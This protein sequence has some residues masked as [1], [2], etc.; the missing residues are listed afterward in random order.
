MTTARTVTWLKAGPAREVSWI[1]AGKPTQVITTGEGAR[2]WVDAGPP[3]I[4][5]GAAV[6]DFYLNSTTGDI[7]RLD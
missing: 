2:I 7:Y 4:V 3:T 1:H 6:G 5:P